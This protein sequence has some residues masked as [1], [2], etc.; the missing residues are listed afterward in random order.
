MFARGGLHPCKGH[1]AQIFVLDHVLKIIL[2][3]FCKQHGKMDITWTKQAWMMSSSKSCRRTME[4]RLLKS[5][6]QAWWHSCA[7]LLPATSLD[8]A[9]AWMAGSR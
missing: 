5:I 1:A 8:K 7:L 2:L 3:S 9:Y 6:V 4:I